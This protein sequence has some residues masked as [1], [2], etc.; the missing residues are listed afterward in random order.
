MIKELSWVH[1]KL[2]KDECMRIVML[3]NDW[4]IHVD[5]TD[6]VGEFHGTFRVVRSNGKIVSIN[7]DAVALVCT[8][9]KE[10]RL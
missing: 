6:L 1:S 10:V 7:P 9:K 5:K 4:E 3:R 2:T 8:M